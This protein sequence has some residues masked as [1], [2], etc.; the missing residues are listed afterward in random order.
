MWSEFWYKWRLNVWSF[1]FFHWSICILGVLT[2][3]YFN[4]L[5]TLIVIVKYFIYVCKLKNQ[6]PVWKD[7]VEYIKYCKKNWFWFSVLVYPKK[8]N[9]LKCKWNSISS[10][11]QWVWC[12]Q[13]LILGCCLDISANKSCKLVCE[14][15]SF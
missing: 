3:Q 10:M 1:F 6:I 5:N 13:S 15:G 7:C 11:L 14:E 4:I 9:S 12:S 2:G 8:S